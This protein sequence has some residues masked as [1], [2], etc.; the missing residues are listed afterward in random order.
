MPKEIS[1]Q[2]QATDQTFTTAEPGQIKDKNSR[3]QYIFLIY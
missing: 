2:R 1:L 3:F